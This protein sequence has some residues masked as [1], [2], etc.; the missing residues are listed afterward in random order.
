MCKS[1]K[2]DYKNHSYFFKLLLLIIV[3]IFDP[4][5]KENQLHTTKNIR[6]QFNNYN[7]II[8]RTTSPS[9]NNEMSGNEVK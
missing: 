9:F 2:I 8:C 1:V 7:L 6:V 3:L 4:S 5:G